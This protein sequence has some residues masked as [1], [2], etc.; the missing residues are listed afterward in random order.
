MVTLP[1][2]PVEWPADSCSAMLLASLTDPEAWPLP[3]AM[4]MLPV[5]PV[6]LPPVWMCIFPAACVADPVLRETLPL[7]ADAEP[8]VRDTSPED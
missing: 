8:V 4:W 6:E 5:L 2:V 7:P 1:C 3:V